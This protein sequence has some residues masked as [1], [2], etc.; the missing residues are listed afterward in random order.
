ME[1]RWTPLQQP[2]TSDPI[3]FT[4]AVMENVRIENGDMSA[5]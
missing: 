3:A 1:E 2:D 4:Q 5:L